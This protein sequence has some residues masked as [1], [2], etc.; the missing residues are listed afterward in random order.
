MNPNVESYISILT[1]KDAG[2]KPTIDELTDEQLYHFC[3]EEDLID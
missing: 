1:K 3:I 2:I